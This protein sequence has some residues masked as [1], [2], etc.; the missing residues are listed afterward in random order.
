MSGAF[1]SFKR[2]IHDDLRSKTNATTNRNIRTVAG[3][4]SNFLVTALARQTGPKVRK[5]NENY[6]RKWKYRT[7]DFRERND[8]LES[9]ITDG[10][11]INER[12]AVRLLRPKW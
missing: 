5:I 8:K 1:R 2:T 3:K 9:S 6:R 10:S 11:T 12:N 7:I 4:I